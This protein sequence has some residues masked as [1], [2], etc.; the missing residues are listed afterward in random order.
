MCEYVCVCVSLSISTH[1][2]SG[3]EASSQL[4][5]SMLCGHGVRHSTIHRTYFSTYPYPSGTV[6]LFGYTRDASRG[7]PDLFSHLLSPTAI[8]CVATPASSGLCRAAATRG[9]TGHFISWLDRSAPA[10]ASS[11][12]NTGITSRPLVR[13]GRRQVITRSETRPRR[14]RG[15]GKKQTVTCHGTALGTYC[16]TYLYIHT[17]ASSMT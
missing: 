16:T 1:H 13:D 6:P 9:W 2:Q 3:Q 7:K 11:F 4:H 17:L 14:P 8:A 12:F 5:K 10:F 15:G